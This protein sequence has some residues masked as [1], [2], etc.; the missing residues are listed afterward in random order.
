MPYSATPSPTQSPTRQRLLSI[1]VN[2]ASSSSGGRRFSTLDS[3]MERRTSSDSMEER[4][5]VDEIDTSNA[6]MNGLSS[7]V[8]LQQSDVSSKEVVES[9]SCAMCV[10]ECSCTKKSSNEEETQPEQ[11]IVCPY[12]PFLRS[13]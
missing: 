6:E 11:R 5:S 10:D 13:E 2:W 1:S 12:E 8:D 3:I 9:E 4:K 7:E